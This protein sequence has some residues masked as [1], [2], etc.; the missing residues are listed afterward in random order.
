MVKI[1]LINNNNFPNDK[2][3][4]FLTSMDKEYPVAL[5]SK[6]DFDT[7]LNKVKEKG[8]IYCAYEKDRIIGA[9]FFY[10]NNFK[11]K[12]A[13]L[14]LLGVTR[15][16]RNQHIA[17]KL[18]KK[19]INKCKENFEKIQLYTHSSNEIAINFYKKNGFYS[20]SSDRKGDL[21]LEL[22]LKEEKI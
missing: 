17:T 5:S 7:F 22:Q 21:K 1:E 12:I 9:L 10:A 16:Y 8:N 14:T 11:E 4:I 20:I 15:E 3:K 6:T 2:L 13:F 19:M 18:L